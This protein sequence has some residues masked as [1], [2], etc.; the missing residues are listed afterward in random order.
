MFISRCAGKLRQRPEKRFRFLIH[1]FP[2]FL[3]NAF[4]L[5][6]KQ[7]FSKRSD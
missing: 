6:E 2:S 5:L 1:I 4:I 3:C 7:P